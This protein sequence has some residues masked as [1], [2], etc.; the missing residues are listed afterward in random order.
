MIN[1]SSLLIDDQGFPEAGYIALINSTNITV[2]NL[3]LDKGSIFFAFTGNSTIRNSSISY[4]TI[5]LTY[6][7][8]NIVSGNTL[9][10]NSTITLEFCWDNYVNKNTATN[11]SVLT[12]GSIA[13]YYSEGN[14]VIAGNLVANSTAGFCVFESSR[15]KIIENHIINNAF[16]IRLENSNMTVIY[17]NNF[18]DNENQTYL[19]QAFNNVWDDGYPSGGNYWSDYTGIDS[20]NG[21]Y[22]NETGSDGIGDAAYEI[23]AYNRDEYPLMAPFNTFDV[24][25]W[26]GKLCSVEIISNSTLSDFELNTTKKTISFNVA[27]IETNAGFCRI[28]I[29]N[30]IVQDLW[31]GNYTVLL[32]GKPWPFRNWTDETNSYIY[33]NYTHS[34]HEIVIIP[35]FPSNLVMPFWMLVT[36]VAIAIMKKRKLKSKF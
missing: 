3:S 19:W 1:Q 27:G 15:D 11:N 25:M 33:V 32:D 36:M 12:W 29:P 8:N 14:N 7:K 22:Q 4:G 30:V 21:P 31:Q 35:E 17:H 2:E 13:L 18:I 20:Y 5:W 28:T 26:N 24:G 10:L 34:E 6:S 23:D 9:S 16:G